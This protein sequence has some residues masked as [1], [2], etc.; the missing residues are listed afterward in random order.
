VGDRVAA[1]QLVAHVGQPAL[2][3]KLKVAREMLDRARRERMEFLSMHSNQAR[4]RVEAVE[5]QQHNNDR[6]IQDLQE[7]SKLAAEQ[8]KIDDELLTRGLVTRQQ[9]LTARQNLKN[10]EAQIATHQADIKQLEAQRSEF[11]FKPAETDADVRS[12]IAELEHNLSEVEKELELNSSVIS[13]YAGE[14]IELK[15][16]PAGTVAADTPVMSI[17][18]ENDN[19]EVL[20]YVPSLRAKEIRAQM[21]AQVSPS[22]FNRE[23]YGFVRGKVE[24]V[25]DFPSTRAALMRNFENEALVNALTSSGPVTEVTVHMVVDAK[26]PSGFQWSSSQGPP[27]RLSGGTMCTLQVV[28]MRQKPAAL[29]LPFLKAKLGV[30]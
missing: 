21:E 11:A 10:I 22:I 12:R 29:L 14:V 4:L 3:E 1:N 17:Q 9:T 19:L 20:A 2:A 25:A 7:Q 27:L 15:A 6:Q 18:P 24:Y 5:R 30:D 16:Y 8:V 23:E 13:P 26:S 28:T